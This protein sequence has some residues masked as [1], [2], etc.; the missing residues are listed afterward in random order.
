MGMTSIA[1]AGLTSSLGCSSS[2]KKVSNDLIPD[3]KGILDLPPGFTY[4]MISETGQDMEGG[5]KVPERPDG[6]A[7]FSIPNGDIALIRNHEILA[8]MTPFIP[9]SA[10]LKDVP[11]EQAYDGF[12]DSDLRLA[13]GTSTIILDAKSLEK[14]R[15]F[16][17]LLGT[18]WNCAGGSTPWNTWISCE[19]NENKAFDKIDLARYVEWG[20]LSDE[21]AKEFDLRVE[22][23]HGYAFEVDP[24]NDGLSSPE[25]LRNLGRFK[26]EAIAVDPRNNI[27]YQTEDDRLGLFYRFI[28]QNSKFSGKLQALKIKN[29]EK[30]NTQNA[31]SEIKEG[32]RYEVEWVNIE[33]YE[34]QN[35]KLREHGFNELGATQFVRGEGITVATDGVYFVCTE[36]GYNRLGQIWKYSPSQLEGKKNEQSTPGYIELFY[37][38]RSK[39]EFFMGDNLTVSPWGDLIVCEDNY[40]VSS[41]NRILGIRPDGTVYKLANNPGSSSEFAGACFSPDN[42]ILFVNLQIDP[43]R[44]FAIRGDWKMLRK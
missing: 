2:R 27:I 42:S 13:G 28:P 9:N 43:G 11:R 22:K 19:E 41:S 31:S 17:S 7:A 8:E 3:P 25:P 34:A 44:T 26:R 18:Q 35:Y 10:K 29:K 33:D 16:Y 14:K 37:E 1:F 30:F 12:V 23:D 39:E 36:G 6:M 40:S 24:L 4:S 20:L 15:E 38:S 5:F 32:I 21:Q